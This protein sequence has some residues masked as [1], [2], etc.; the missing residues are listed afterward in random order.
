MRARLDISYDG[1]C[2]QGFQ[3]QK[4]TEKTVMNFFLKALKHLNIYENPIGCGR[5]DAK[6]HALNQTLHL[7]IPLFWKD[8]IRLKNALNLYLHPYVHVN[9]IKEVSND[10]HACFNAYKR[11]YRY[12]VWHGKYM[13]QLANYFVQS[14]SFDHS[15]I[16]SALGIFIGK[17]NFKLFKKSGSF[18]KHNERTIYEAK[19]YKKGDL[20][21]FTFK[22]NGF[23]R[24][25]VRLMVGASLAYAN[26]NLSLNQIEEQLRCKKSHFHK[27]APPQG[28][29]FVRGFYPLCTHTP[30]T[31]V[32]S[33]LP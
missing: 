16:N 5:T 15:K 24:A 8:L 32:A 20:S 21:I 6:V 9:S 12:I 1:S 29:Y 4:H 26:G 13:P 23:L 14:P 25:Q 28:L 19:C 10:F 33:I 11:H 30:S 22:A 31:K 3:H 18:T 27:P 2:F 17:H 7:D